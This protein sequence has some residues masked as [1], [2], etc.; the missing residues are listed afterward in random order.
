MLEQPFEV[1]VEYAP[2][3][4]GAWIPLS[5]AP[6]VAV[7]TEFTAGFAHLINRTMREQ[8]WD[9]VVVEPCLEVGQWRTLRMGLELVVVLQTLE[10]DEPVPVFHHK[11]G[12][13]GDVTE[14][15]TSQR[16]VQ[17]RHCARVRK[18]RN[19]DFHNL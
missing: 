17:L 14:L 3:N 10:N 1:A 16:K 6:G 15:D 5:V 12:G 2:S 7:A 11:E 9:V 4:E 8:L 18:V 13:I 19:K